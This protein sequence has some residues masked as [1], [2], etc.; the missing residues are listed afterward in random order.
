MW[1][2]EIIDWGLA[3]PKRHEGRGRVK[4]TDMMVT[5]AP[6]PPFRPRWNIHW[7]IPP[8]AHFKLVERG[9]K[10]LKEGSLNS[11]NRF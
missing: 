6:E 9:L 8:A 3:G 2:S 7:R 5:Q 1:G 4:E 10:N 11:Q